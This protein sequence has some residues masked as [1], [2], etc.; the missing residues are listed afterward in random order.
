MV[1]VKTRSVF[2]VVWVSVVTAW[3]ARPGTS[4][5]FD[6]DC[7]S[8]GAGASL[9]TFEKPGPQKVAR[10]WR[11]MPRWQLDLRSLGPEYPPG[12]VKNRGPAESICFT[13]DNLLVVTFSR[14][15]DLTT[16]RGSAERSPAQP[17]RLRAL[18][19]DGV[20]GQVRNTREWSIRSGDGSIVPT[21]AGN[22]LLFAPD[23]LALYSSDLQPLKDMPLP[24]AGFESESGP[25]VRHSPSGKSI[26][27]VYRADA[28]NREGGYV[29]RSHYDFVWIDSKNLA[30]VRAWRENGWENTWHGPELINTLG[31]YAGSISDSEM[32][33]GLGGAIILRKFDGPWRLVCY[34]QPYCGEPQFVDNRTLLM[35][36]HQVPRALGENTIGLLSTDGKLQFKQQIGYKAGDRLGPAE[37]SA[38]GRRFA[39]LVYREEGELDIADYHLRSPH[40]VLRSVM[41]YDIPGRH[42]V[43]AVEA[44]NKH[45]R[46]RITSRGPLL[47]PKLAL[48][49]D[50]CLLAILSDG[51]IEVYQLPAPRPESPSSTHADR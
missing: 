15:D 1:R 38:D 29:D 43:Y 12:S 16:V 32:V 47:L 50:G 21:T 37:V 20:T 22:F 8:T 27:L 36:L 13:S 28:S 19:V 39:L 4:T 48:S 7:L 40:L 42:W 6:F 30:V 3:F 14:M 11:E 23:H 35:Y 46:I 33:R 24:P 45:N 26:L 2:L 41:V 34:L 31:G 25:A 17:S 44:D 10:R 49:P 5:A 18:F 51:L 9:T